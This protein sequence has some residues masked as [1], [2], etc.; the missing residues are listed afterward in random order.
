MAGFESLR[1]YVLDGISDADV[2]ASTKELERHAGKL[3]LAR[4]LKNPQEVATELVTA[5]PQ[6]DSDRPSATLAVLKITDPALPVVWGEPRWDGFAAEVEAELE[7]RGSTPADDA[8]KALQKELKSAESR[9]A[10]EYAAS[11][12]PG[13]EFL[14]SADERLL[15]RLFEALRGFVRRAFKPIKNLAAALGSVLE[16]PDS[17]YL[18]LRG[19]VSEYLGRHG[20]GGLADLL[21]VLPDL[22][23]LYIRLLID[24]RVSTDIKKRLLA[25][26]A[27]LVLPADLIPDFL[28]PVGYVDD[29]WI[30]L[31]LLAELTNTHS[32]S[33]GL[34]R[35]HWAGPEE[36]LPRIQNISDWVPDHMELLER[37][38]QSFARSAAPQ[39]A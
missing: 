4:G 3:R 6:K 14:E 39:P 24:R 15:T 18:R 35:E 36:W 25:A 19:E 29:A 9:D 21:F 13:A 16:D 17:Y 26:V 10:A 7:R 37:I 8:W 31:R 1:G 23:R 30:L 34:L 27:Y 5:P 20:P 22:F 11:F 32:V 2:R 28:G 33:E 12:L 38:W